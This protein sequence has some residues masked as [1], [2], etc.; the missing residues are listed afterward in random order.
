M[1]DEKLKTKLDWALY[2]QNLGLSIIPVGLNKKSLVDWKIYEDRSPNVDEINLISTV[3][4][5]A[6]EDLELRK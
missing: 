3:S 2:Y 4:S 6:T 5:C 1:N